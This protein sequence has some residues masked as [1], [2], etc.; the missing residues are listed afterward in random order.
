M[1]T[2]SVDRTLRRAA[3]LLTLL[4][5]GCGGGG[6][7]DTE[8][9]QPLAAGRPTADIVLTSAA[10]GVVLTSDSRWNLSKRGT[11]SGNTVSWTVEVSRAPTIA[12]RLG[13]QGQMT[14]ANS[15]SG[16][17]TIGNVVVNLQK[18]SGGKW[19]TA[20]SNVADATQGDDATA[21]RIHAA[22]SSENRSS[23]SE[24]SASG[25]L[26]FMDAANN[27]VFSLVPQAVIAAGSSKVLLFTAVFDNNDAALQLAPGTQIRAEV[28]VSFGNA[29]AKGNSTTDVDIN[30][31]G[32]IDA[33]EARVRSV[34]SRL[35]LT[36][37]NAIDASGSVALTDT[38]DDI[39][40]TGDVTFSNL[41]FSLG[42][43]GGTVTANVTGGTRGG[44]ITNC[45]RLKSADQTVGVGGYSF[46]VAD[47]VDLQ[48]CST[49]EVAA[50]PPG[51]TPGAPGC[52]WKTGDMET[53][54][55]A[56][57]GDSSSAAG[58]TL[59]STFNSFYPGDLVVG[60]TNQLRFTDSSTVF[61]YLPATGSPG[62]LTNSIVDPITTSAGDF[63]GEVT[64]LKLNIEHSSQFG[65]AAPL[66]SLTICA[67]ATLP[68]MNGQTVAQFLAV[69]NH[70]L[71]GGSSTITASQAAAL[72]RFI[73]NAFVDGAPSAF[74]QAN[75][76]AGPGC[77]WKTG[78]MV[79]ASQSDW[80]DGASA[81]GTTLAAN[82]T[83]FYGGTGL[84]IGGTNTMTF[85]A[86]SAVLTYLP[87]GGTSGALTGSL[88]NPLSSSAGE[89]G[90][91]VLAL[92]LNVDFSSTF[93][94]AVSLGA[95]RIC[96]FSA[97]P[98]LNGQTVDEFLTTANWVLGGG[99]AAFGPTVGAAVANQINN[100]FASGTPSSFAQTNLVAGNCPAGGWKTG[101]VT[102]A[103]ETQWGDGGSSAGA[104][105]AANFSANYAAAGLAVGGTRTMTFTSANAVFEYLPTAG[106]PAALD[107]SLIN[108]LTSA[109]GDF[110]GEVVAL[111]LNVDLSSALGNK[112]S[113]GGLRICGFAAVP[114]LNGQTVEQFLTTANVI[115]GG[116]S[117]S[118]GAGTASAVATL[119]NSAFQDGSPS[120]FAQEHL[121][122]GNCPAN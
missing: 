99:S 108:P 40:A 100:A 92:Q 76:V 8:R 60:G 52:G 22:A 66:A 3:A 117:A 118:F 14:V 102:T 106:S 97:V 46:A 41:V 80:G 16:P 58:A 28:I 104:S 74:A 9:E 39:S 96:N 120:T 5:A 87:A 11:L 114:S 37:P 69:A 54:S 45:A 89:F 18:R 83:S 81:A 61:S 24:N 68:T 1:R 70:V 27:S 79:T 50:Q 23:F 35:T 110:G 113:L 112:V 53:Y 91:Q 57:W 90:G 20:A 15:G 6:G 78:E 67:L 55:Q 33:D 115:L 10:T 62:A 38:I 121:V 98:S 47:G 21:A 72:A 51:C 103:T 116:G 17:A 95:L 109:S 105:L 30:G 29:P 13:I 101:E 34:P 75:L 111:Q 93:G 77:G 71:G 2:N 31:N 36:V 84:R 64:A 73:N 42:A 63:G 122:A 65:N 7:D 43:T 94:N 85:T 19:V 32:T 88:S 119:I 86:S 25:A 107:G 56:T 26:N 4:L 12:G 59:I 48:A 44:S 82:F 49:V